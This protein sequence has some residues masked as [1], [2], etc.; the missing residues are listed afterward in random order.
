LFRLPSL[1]RF[2]IRYS[3]VTWLAVVSLCLLPVGLSQ[4]GLIPVWLQSALFAL[5]F[6]LLVPPIAWANRRQAQLRGSPG[7]GP[8]FRKRTPVRDWARD[9]RPAT[10]HP[11]RHEQNRRWFGSAAWRAV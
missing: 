7:P 2:L 6:V 8:A 5:L 11:A 3:V 1:R 9:T 4:F 10:R